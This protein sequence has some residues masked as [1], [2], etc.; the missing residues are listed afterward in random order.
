MKFILAVSIAISAL[1]SACGTTTP[2]VVRIAVNF[3]SGISVGQDMLNAV[4][5]ALNEA[6]GKAGNISVELSTLDSSDPNGNPVSVD[7][8]VSTT[9]VAIADPSVVAYIG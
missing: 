8:A 7:L 9:K 3:P 4:Q 6:N 1:L 5:L 2:S